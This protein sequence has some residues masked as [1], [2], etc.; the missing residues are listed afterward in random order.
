MTGRDIPQ[1]IVFFAMMLVTSL[2]C[3]AC[4][5][6]DAWTGIPAANR[7]A[8]TVEPNT[9]VPQGDTT[10][11]SLKPGTPEGDEWDGSSA[12]DPQQP[13]NPAP[14]GGIDEGGDSTETLDPVDPP[15]DEGGDEE[16]PMYG[17]EEG[18]TD[19]VD[20]PETPAAD[21]P[22]SSVATSAP[23]TIDNGSVIIGVAT[24]NQTFASGEALLALTPDG[25]ASFDEVIVS[26]RGDVTTIWARAY[27]NEIP[28]QE[29]VKLDLQ[30]SDGPNH[31]ASVTFADRCT[32][33]AI[34]VAQGTAVSEATLWVN[35]PMAPGG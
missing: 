31:A 25:A 12:P 16:S 27:D 33:V 35:T 17:E 23:I 5:D 13:T 15:E 1:T 3:T 22:P 9:E 24:A 4:G 29:W 28:R 6:S 2:W 32:G 14:G 11:D 19:P 20:P 26:W 34:Y 10:I 7:R 30:V 8:P 18:G 21:Q